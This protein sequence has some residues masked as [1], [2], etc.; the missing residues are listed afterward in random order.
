MTRPDPLT[1]GQLRA[2]LASVGS[3][4]DH[5]IVKLKVVDDEEWDED[6]FLLP[7]TSYETENGKAIYGNDSAALITLKIGYE[8]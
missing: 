8:L 4:H 7:M 1:L 2:F 3:E 6:F 5:R